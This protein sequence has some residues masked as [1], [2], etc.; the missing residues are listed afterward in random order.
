MLIYIGLV[1]VLTNLHTAPRYSDS[2]PSCPVFSVSTSMDKIDISHPW[3]VVL[4]DIGNLAP[5]LIVPLLKLNILGSENAKGFLLLVQQLHT[6]LVF[7]G[8]VPSGG[9]P[10]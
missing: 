1:P 2:I 4:K 6:H 9:I 8:T 3:S 5:A 10:V 7:T